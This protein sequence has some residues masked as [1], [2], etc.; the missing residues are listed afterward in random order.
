[1]GVKDGVSSIQTQLRHLPASS[2]KWG[3]VS[4]QEAP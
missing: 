3:Q 1:M 2:T 4:A